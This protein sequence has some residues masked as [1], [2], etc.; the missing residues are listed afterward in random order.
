MQDVVG[1]RASEAFIFHAVVEF[2]E[3]ALTFWV[4]FLSPIPLMDGNPDFSI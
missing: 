3:R 1:I 2:L 4:I